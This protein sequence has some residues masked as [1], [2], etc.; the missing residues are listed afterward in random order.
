M[1]PD[2]SGSHSCFNLLA[3]SQL[4]GDSEIPGYLEFWAEQRHSC[5]K[6]WNQV[7]QL[8]SKDVQRFLGH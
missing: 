6:F 2:D 8:M 7:K 5:I 1:E 4:C 3:L